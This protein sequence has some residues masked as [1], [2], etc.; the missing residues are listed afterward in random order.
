MLYGS[1]RCLWLLFLLMLHLLLL[2]LLLQLLVRF[3]L[4]YPERL[5]QALVI[6]APAW[7]ST[8]WKAMSAFMDENTR[9]GLG[10]QA[11]SGY[12]HTV[13]ASDVCP[14]LHSLSL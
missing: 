7:F 8:P 3:G 5:R 10:L 2:L 9:W 1:C 14:G 11:K 12:W 6:N 4:Y 13:D